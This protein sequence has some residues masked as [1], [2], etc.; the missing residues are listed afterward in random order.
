[1][2][3]FGNR[4]GTHTTQRG[5]TER[6][7]AVWRHSRSNI[8][9]IQKSNKAKQIS[10]L[11]N[12]QTRVDEIRDELEK[13]KFAIR[14]I[15]NRYSRLWRIQAIA[16]AVIIGAIVGNLFSNVTA[17]GSYATVIGAG[18]FSLSAILA[19]LWMRLR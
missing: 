12:F 16:G 6:E 11:T 10:Q 18:V 19:F 1:M 9:N 17:V 13:S 3:E 2:A 5:Q 4:V 7:R 8:D 14:Q 15:E